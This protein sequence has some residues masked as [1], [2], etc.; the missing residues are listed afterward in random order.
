IV[1]E[2][3]EMLA[4]IMETLEQ[5]RTDIGNEI[6]MALREQNTLGRC[7]TCEDGKI[8]AMR[9]R[10]NKRFAGCLNY[11]DCRQSYPLPQ[12]GRIEGTWENCETCGAPRIALFAKGRG[13]T[14]FCIN[15]DCPSNEERLKEIAEAKARRAAKAAKGKKGG[16]KKEG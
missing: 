9:S 1:A 14:E 12:R 4:G 6:K 11:P 2:S 3:R 8:I 13:R 15:M 5:E 10:R 7:P 16:G